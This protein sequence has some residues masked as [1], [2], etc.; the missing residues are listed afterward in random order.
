[1]LN[2]EVLSAL[3]AWFSE[4][5]KIFRS[6]D[7]VTQQNMDMKE[8]HSR[9]VCAEIKEIGKSLDLNQEDLHLAEV[10]ALLHDVGRFVQYARY[11]T[12]LDLRSEDHT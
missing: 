10:I 5:V 2:K 3:K 1:M 6:E 8:H 7:P 4:Y 11:G 9:R 12:F